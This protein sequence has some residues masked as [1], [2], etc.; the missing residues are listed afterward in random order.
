MEEK[1][2]DLKYIMVVI[3]GLWRHSSSTPA[4]EILSEAGDDSSVVQI[5]DDEAWNKIESGKRKALLRRQRDILAKKVRANL[6]KVSA[7]ASPFKKN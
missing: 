4:D 2:S 3:R 6:C 7:N 5:E 1:N